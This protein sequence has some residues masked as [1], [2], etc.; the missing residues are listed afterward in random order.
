L[1][2][3][4]GQLV[5]MV[6]AMNVVVFA[7]VVAAALAFHA[8][9]LVTLVLVTLAV[10]PVMPLFTGKA[11]KAGIESDY[12]VGVMVASSLLAI[13]L[14]PLSI[15]FCGRVAGTPATMPLT[16]VARLIAGTILAPLAAG[17]L[18][19][20]LIPGASRFS[21][22]AGIIA[23]LTLVLAFL[24]VLV[25]AWPSIVTLIRNGTLIPLAL[26]VVVGLVSGQ[27]IGG[28]TQKERSALAVASACRHPGL[29]IAIAQAN[30][31]DMKLVLPAMILYALVLGVVLLPY[32]KWSARRLATASGSR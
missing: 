6:L 5:R 12:A 14:V 19:R 15:E 22:P 13:V 28:P 16:A 3:H 27:V 17:M 23:M 30:V 25:K 18:V 32:N 20:R 31:P 29:A 9:P 7:A 10:S 1:F 24:P 2:R 4:P 8:D 21:K 11:T 26:F